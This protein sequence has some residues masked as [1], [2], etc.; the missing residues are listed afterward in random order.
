MHLRDLSKS[1]RKL[2]Q[3]LGLALH[4]RSSWTSIVFSIALCLPQISL[5]IWAYKSP[6]RNELDLWLSLWRNL[7]AG[8]IKLSSLH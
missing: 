4:K 3:A 5:G 8:A 2:S 6:L 7:R 1:S